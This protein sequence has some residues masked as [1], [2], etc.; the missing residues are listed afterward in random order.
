MFVNSLNESHLLHI[1]TCNHQF[2]LWDSFVI[3]II[4]KMR[5]K[6]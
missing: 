4:K 2:L 3:A 6:Y 1:Y 5:Y